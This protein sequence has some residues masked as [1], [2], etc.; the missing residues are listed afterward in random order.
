[1][2]PVSAM[3][4][5]QH[6]NT[7]ALFIQTISHL[8]HNSCGRT[9]TRSAHRAVAAGCGPLEHDALLPAPIR[10][11]PVHTCIH[12]YSILVHNSCGHTHTLY[13]ELWLLGVAP[14]GMMPYFQHHF[15]SPM[16]G[17]TGGAGAADPGISRDSS[18]QQLV[19]VLFPN[20]TFIYARFLEMHVASF[21]SMGILRVAAG[22]CQ[23]C[24]WH[25]FILI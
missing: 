25:V 14:L 7:N 23:T 17:S 6:Q 24:I 10:K 9:H 18:G 2:V 12:T 11:C 4:Y 16:G 20:F 22:A 19:C 5:S 3:P 15:E 13:A 8:V 21:R 1:M